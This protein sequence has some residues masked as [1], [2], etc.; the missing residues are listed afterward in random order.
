[1]DVDVLCSEA[2]YKD[3]HSKALEAGL[4]QSPSSFFCV[5]G[6]PA[7]KEYFGGALGNPHFSVTSLETVRAQFEAYQ[8]V[9]L[10]IWTHAR[11]VHDPRG[12]F[13]GIRGQFRGYP[14]AERI[15]KIKYHWLAAGYLAIEMRPRGRDRI[16]SAVAGLSGAILELLRVFFLVEDRPYP[17]PAKLLTCARET[18]LGQRFCPLLSEAAADI[19]GQNLP[20]PPAERLEQ[21]F[22]RLFCADLSQD[23]TKLQEACEAAMVAAGVPEEWVQ[24]DFENVDQLLNGELGPFVL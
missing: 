3:L 4:I 17:Y 15:R 24:A 18:A 8:D 16:L 14:E 9:P 10:W 23:A 11:V 5:Q 22:E 6:D 13:D 1:V 19:A 12:Q 7:A 21:V 20:S 2:L